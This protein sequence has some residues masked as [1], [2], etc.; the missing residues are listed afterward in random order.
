MHVSNRAI[1]FGAHISIFD[2]M[3]KRCEGFTEG[4]VDPE[5]IDKLVKS[6]EAE[7]VFIPLRLDILIYQPLKSASRP[8]FWPFRAVYVSRLHYPILECCNSNC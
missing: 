2:I 7:P 3:L 1:S 5:W 6:G 4:V 8:L